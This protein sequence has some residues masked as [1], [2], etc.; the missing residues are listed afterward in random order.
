MKIQKATR[1]ETM[2]IAIG[3]ILLAALMNVVYLL[4][5]SW[6]VGV[7]FGSILGSV[8]A[9]GNFFFLALTVQKAAYEDEKRAKQWLQ[10]SYSLRMLFMG[11][12]MVLGFVLPWTEGLPC[13]L[14]LFFPRVTILAM[15]VTG[16]YKPEKTKKG[17]DDG[18]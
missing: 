8:G 3:V 10:F 12:V 2:H 17:E 4:I 13:A 11:G 18:E 9:I 16:R 6:S 1:Q 7:L 15:Q 14:C 5:K